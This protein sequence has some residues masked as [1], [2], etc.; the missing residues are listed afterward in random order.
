MAL[1]SVEL[2]LVP[3]ALAEAVR[4]RVA[5]LRLDAVVVAATHTHAGP[6]GYWDALAGQLGATGPY[7]AAAFERLVES[8]AG[9]IRLAAAAR[10]PA[11]V[12]V[13][14]GRLAEAGA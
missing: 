12:S 13:A 5:D 1:V 14:R 7:D 3:R 11:T 9:A 8:M 2:V 10:G 4:A 6:G